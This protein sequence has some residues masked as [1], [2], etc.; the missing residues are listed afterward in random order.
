MIL[1]Q[2]MVLMLAL[3][4]S[5]DPREKETARCR[6]NLLAD[7]LADLESRI[8]GTLGDEPAP[9][10]GGESQDETRKDRP[11]VPRQDLVKP[12]ASMVDFDWMEIQ[13]RVGMAIFSKDYHVSPS[14]AFGVSVRAPLTW[15]SPSSNPDGEYFGI[16]G[17]L[18]VAIIKRTIVPVL[19]KPSGPIFMATIGLDYT[20]YRNETWMLLVEGGM[21]YC[22]YGGITDLKNGYAPVG[23]LKVGVSLSRTVSL[24]FNPE[25]V[26]AGGNHIIL[27]WISATVEF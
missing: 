6:L 1:L 7:P 27:A 17:Q 2:S 16:F 25:F 9:E 8:G 4:G 3:G 24:A 20:I 13:P 5:G 18:D 19:D 12:Q 14:P 10:N 22:F 26:M 15:L 21:Q 23:G 11:E